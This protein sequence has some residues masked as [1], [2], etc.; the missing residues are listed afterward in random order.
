MKR[1]ILT[2]LV[3]TVILSG[4]VIT[5]Y[6]VCLNM[7][8]KAMEEHKDQ[9]EYEQSI[10]NLNRTIQRAEEAIKGGEQVGKK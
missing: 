9:E 10:R 8:V 5:T 4:A 1:I 6:T 3:L 7:T 2:V